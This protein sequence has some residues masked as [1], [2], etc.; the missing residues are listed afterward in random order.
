MTV[1]TQ[2]VHEYL[3]EPEV[4]RDIPEETMLVVQGGT[5]TVGDCNPQLSRAPV[6]SQTPLVLP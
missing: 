6:T 2:R 1:S 5:V 4:F 3:V